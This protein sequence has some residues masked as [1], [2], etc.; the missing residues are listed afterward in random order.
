MPGHESLLLAVARAWHCSLLPLVPADAG[1]ALAAFDRLC[2][3]QPARQSMPWRFASHNESGLGFLL[4]AR[5]SKALS[6]L[7]WS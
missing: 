5:G 6:F 7:I 3:W 4:A 1:F 2:N